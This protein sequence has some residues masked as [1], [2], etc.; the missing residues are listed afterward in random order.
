MDPFIKVVAANSSS[1]KA[2]LFRVY[3]QIVFILIKLLFPKCFT[4]SISLEMTLFER[5]YISVL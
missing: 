1:S 4:Y 2:T 5:V 3:S